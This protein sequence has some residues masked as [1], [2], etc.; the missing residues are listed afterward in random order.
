MGIITKIKKGCC[1]L[2]GVGL[3]DMLATAYIP[4]DSEYYMLNLAIGAGIAF[5]GGTCAIWIGPC[6]QRAERQRLLTESENQHYIPPPPTLAPDPTPPILAPDPTPP[7]TLPESQNQSVD[8]VGAGLAS[9]NLERK[10][11]LGL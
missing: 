6:C 8:E 9:P 5:V 10:S 7:S 4:R 3:L 11:R 1:T 2:M